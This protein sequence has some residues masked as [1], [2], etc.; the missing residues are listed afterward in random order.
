VELVRDWGGT[1]QLVRRTARWTC[2]LQQYMIDA[3]ST[4]KEIET[5]LENT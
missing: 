1:R 4:I 5:R 2:R 3:Q